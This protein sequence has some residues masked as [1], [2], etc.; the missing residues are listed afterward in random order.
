MTP[1][2]VRSRPPIQRTTRWAPSATTAA[3]ERGVTGHGR[4]SGL[5]LEQIVAVFEIRGPAQEHALPAAR[6]AGDDQRTD[7]RQAAIV[8]SDSKPADPSLERETIP[9][10]KCVD[11]ARRRGNDGKVDLTIAAPRTAPNVGDP[12][13]VEQACDVER[14]RRASDD[15]HRSARQALCRD[16]RS[17]VESGGN[18]VSGGAKIGGS[19]RALDEQAVTVEQL[20]G[21]R[22]RRSGRRPEPRGQLVERS[23]AVEQGKQRRHEHTHGAALEHDDRLPM[24]EQEPVAIADEAIPRCEQR[25]LQGR[26]SPREAVEHEDEQQQQARTAANPAEPRPATV[27]RRSSSSAVSSAKITCSP[28]GSRSRCSCSTR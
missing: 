20:E 10:R 26:Q 24:F 17:H 15:R 7:R 3:C 23:G 2:R 9:L 14:S 5:D 21:E 22:D 27:A 25:P 6:L 12:C 8:G 28:P 13:S 4:R 11:L 1:G 18:G 16:Y 19:I